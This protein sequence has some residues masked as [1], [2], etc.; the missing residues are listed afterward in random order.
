VGVTCISR[1]S[2]SNLIMTVEMTVDA[3]MVEQNARFYAGLQVQEM[4][5]W[6]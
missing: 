6:E 1:A 5:E 2:R 3:L 4:I